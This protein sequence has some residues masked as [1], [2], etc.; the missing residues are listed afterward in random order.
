MH[1]NEKEAGINWQHRAHKAKKNTIQYVLD[2]TM[3]KQTMCRKCMYIL[4]TSWYIYIFATKSCSTQPLF[5]E[6]P[7]YQTRKVSDS[8]LGINFDS[9]YD[10]SIRC[11]NC[12]FIFHF[13]C[14]FIAKTGVPFQCFNTYI[15]TL[16][17]KWKRMR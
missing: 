2:T 15:C 12:I 14:L 6:V 1:F 11:L 3:Y 5:I 17:V 13:I 8:L 16:V 9:F 7:I 4:I 10:S